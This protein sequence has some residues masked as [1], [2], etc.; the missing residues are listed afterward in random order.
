MKQNRIK[1]SEI[2]KLAFEF[3]KFLLE[4]EAYTTKALCKQAFQIYATCERS[5]RVWASP[6]DVETLAKY[7]VID[8]VK[9]LHFK[10]WNEKTKLY[11]INVYFQFP[12]E[13][14]MRLPMDRYGG[15]SRTYYAGNLDHRESIPEFE[16][17]IQS[18]IQHRQRLQDEA[19]AFKTYLDTRPLWSKAIE[20]WPHLK[21][22]PAT[23]KVN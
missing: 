8:K 5:M 11:D 3:Q 6:E 18:A 17:L 21:P 16:E 1:K 20:A 10:V 23:D 14:V 2:F 9:A 22:Q 7:N 19:N 4:R 15:E 13:H 12:E